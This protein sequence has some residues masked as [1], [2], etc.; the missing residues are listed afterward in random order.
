MN[1]LTRIEMTEDQW[2][3]T[4]HPMYNHFDN[5]DTRNPRF[6]TYGQEVE[7]IYKL[8]P[9]HVW[10]EMDGD[11]GGIYIVEGRH[12][13]NRQAYYVTAYPWKEGESYDICAVEPDEDEDYE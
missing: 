5:Q 11:D 7:Y 4:F 8:D 1:E 3:D 9:H 6:E 2:W 13:V 10:T 12:Y